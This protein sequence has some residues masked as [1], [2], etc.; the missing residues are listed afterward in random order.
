MK[1]I[2]IMNQKG[3]TGKSTLAVNLSHALALKG[4]KVLLVDVDPQGSSTIYL[5]PEFEKTIANVLIHKE[6]AK[7]AIINVR[8]NLD[9]IP[10]NKTV[11]PVSMLIMNEPGREFLLKNAMSKIKGYDYVFIDCAPNLDVLNFNAFA[12]ADETIIP[13]TMDYLSTP[14]MVE[15]IT[16]TLASVKKNLRHN[17]EVSGVIG[18][19]YDQ[20]E[21]KSKKMMESLNKNEFFNGKVFKT[22]IRKNTKIGESPAYGKTIFEYAPSSYG[23]KDYEELANEFLRR[24]GKK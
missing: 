2:C 8:E 22:V 16:D 15:L 21:T 7:D 4:K 12:Y 18:M 20:R 24:G 11:R 19:F 6:D 5:K 1:K 9:L 17:L 13:V 3:G 23:A 14:G 10:S